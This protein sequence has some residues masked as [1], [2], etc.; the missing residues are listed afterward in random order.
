[1]YAESQL[2]GNVPSATLLRMSGKNLHSVTNAQ[3]P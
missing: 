1:M 2:C 3:I